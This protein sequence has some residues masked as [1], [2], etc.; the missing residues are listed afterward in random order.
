MDVCIQPWQLHYSIWGGARHAGVSSRTHKGPKL[1]SME[2][3]DDVVGLD[4]DVYMAVSSWN[5]RS[6]SLVLEFSLL[7]FRKPYISPYVGLWSSESRLYFILPLLLFLFF[8]KGY[9]KSC[10]VLLL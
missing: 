6:I 4:A 10:F 2:L 9:A 1:A 8:L 3:P 5:L 7:V